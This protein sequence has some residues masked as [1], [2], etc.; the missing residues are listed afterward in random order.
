[1]WG[2]W[3]GTSPKGPPCGDVRGDGDL[4]DPHAEMLDGCALRDPRAGVP[5]ATLPCGTSMQRFRGLPILPPQPLGLS[6]V[7]PRGPCRDPTM[8]ARSRSSGALS[9]SRD[10]LVCG[11]RCWLQ[12]PSTSN[13]QCHQ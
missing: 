12:I 4:W 2:C 6:Q 9:L 3:V 5:G 1:M 13:E 10:C 8:G 11:S 7:R